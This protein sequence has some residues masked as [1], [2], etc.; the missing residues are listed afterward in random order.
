MLKAGREEG[1]RSIDWGRVD[2]DGGRDVVTVAVL[3]LLLLLCACRLFGDVAVLLAEAVFSPDLGR[4]D[5]VDD[6]GGCE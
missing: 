2:L 5:V 6:A 1:G 3:L 4:S